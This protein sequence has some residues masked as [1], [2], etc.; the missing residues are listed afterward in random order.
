MIIIINWLVDLFKT[1]FYFL[2]NP[3]FNN[4]KVLFWQGICIALV[5]SAIFFHQISKEV[6]EY[7]FETISSLFKLILSI[8]FNICYWLYDIIS[9]SFI[10]D[11]FAEHFDNDDDNNPFAI[12]Q[13]DD[14][15]TGFGT[16]I[17]APQPSKILTL[18]QLDK[19]ELGAA[20]QQV[21]SKQQFKHQERQRIIEH[22][23]KQMD[24]I[25]QNSSLN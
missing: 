5:I 12:Q 19:V 9:N 25:L 8:I 13:E 18:D 10:G 3:D 4:P 15:N 24:N 7:I 2:T 1:F 14:K 22:Q 20:K 23:Q 11:W 21:I 16:N 17:N 6:I